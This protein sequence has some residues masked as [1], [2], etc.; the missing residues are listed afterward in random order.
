M[1]GF[2]NTIDPDGTAVGGL[3]WVGGAPRPG[4]V[5]QRRPAQSASA[6]T[7]GLPKGPRSFLFGPNAVGGG[8][9]SSVTS[10]PAAGFM[11]AGGGHRGGG[12]GGGQSFEF[13]PAA[14]RDGNRYND[15]GRRPDGRKKISGFS[16]DAAGLPDYTGLDGNAVLQDRSVPAF[17]HG[18]ASKGPASMPEIVQDQREAGWAPGTV[19]DSFDAASG[20]WLPR[21]AD[22]GGVVG[23]FIG[24]ERGPEAQQLQDGSVVPLGDGSPGIFMAPRPVNVIPNH[25]L[26]SPEMNPG[27]GWA[28]GAVT[29]D[30]SGPPSPVRTGSVAAFGGPSADARFTDAAPARQVAAFD[31]APAAAAQEPG[32]LSI[33]RFGGPGA[34]FQRQ[35]RTE[36]RRAFQGRDGQRQLGVFMLNQSLEK[37]RYNQ[38]R[39]DALTDVADERTRKAQAEADAVEGT[40]AAL[41]LAYPA[42]FSP[43]IEGALGRM[44]PS[45]A[46]GFLN[47]IAGHLAQQ[48]RERGASAPGAVPEGYEAVPSEF[49]TS[50]APKKYELVRK[51]EAQDTWVKP[52]PGTTKQIYGA[53]R[54]PMGTIDTTP[55]APEAPKTVKASDG[56]TYQWKDGDWKPLGEAP[57]AKPGRAPVIRELRRPGAPG[58]PDQ[59]DYLEWNQEKQAWGPM[60]MVPGAQTSGKPSAF[61]SKIGQ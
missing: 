20:K 54:N 45:V 28:G 55:Q 34:G 22:G 23:P 21:R 44:K 6:L 53:G 41:K 7:V 3:T 36:T 11:P 50:G 61:L 56:R 37:D 57:S 14:F 31:S 17:Y 9:A 60:T 1:S 26:T 47:G 29:P 5:K 40:K 24:N 18:S 25:A 4:G 27:A 43:E 10:M 15:E 38:R 19:A 32:L 2:V 33:D 51:P 12:G 59:V 13:A 42:A 16:Y 49:T 46:A 30:G 48:D 52:V 35:A 39:A 8:N 58:Q